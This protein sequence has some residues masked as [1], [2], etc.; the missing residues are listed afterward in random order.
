MSFFSKFQGSKDE[1]AG[2]DAPKSA[3]PLSEAEIAVLM[4]PAALSEQAPDTFKAKFETTAGD[5]VIEV[6][7]AWAPLGADR[8]YNLVKN[9]YF[10]GCAFFRYVPGF[11]VQWGIAADPKVSAVWRAA[12]IPDDKFNH[13]NSRGT[14]TFATAGPSTRTTQLFINFKDNSFLDSQGFTPFG[15]VIEGLAVVERLYSGYGEKPDQGSIQAHGAKYIE[16]RF[17]KLDS[18]KSATILA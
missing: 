13:S 8:F 1:P 10:T 6:T 3:A 17:P 14:L 5:F 4:N 12:N 9:K 18:I 11:I 15:S 16:T 2:G 7:R